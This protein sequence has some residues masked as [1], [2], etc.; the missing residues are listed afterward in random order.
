MSDKKTRNEQRK[1]DEGKT[2]PAR[3]KASKPGVANTKADK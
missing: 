1:S 3:Q 2:P